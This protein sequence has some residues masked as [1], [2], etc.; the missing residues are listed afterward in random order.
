MRCRGLNILAVGLVLLGVAM[1]GLWVRSYSVEDSFGKIWPAHG[2]WYE[3]VSE[4]GTIDVK[5]SDDYYVGIVPHALLVVFF[6]GAAAALF[7][8]PRLG[9]ALRRRS[10]RHRGLCSSCG[11]DLRASRERCPECGELIPTGGVKDVKS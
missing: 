9:E 7:C 10:R 8:M 11:Y 2:V 5:H 1:V 3:V 4:G 6:A